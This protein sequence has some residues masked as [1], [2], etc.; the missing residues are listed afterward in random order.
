MSDRWSW[1]RLYGR[2]WSSNPHFMDLGNFS[3]QYQVPRLNKTA[4]RK[5][6]HWISE[7]T[8]YDWMR[9]DH[10]A[11]IDWNIIN[12][13]NKSVALRAGWIFGHRFWKHSSWTSIGS[14]GN[15]CASVCSSQRLS[16]RLPRCPQQSHHFV[17]MNTELIYQPI[18]QTDRLTL[19]PYMWQPLE[20]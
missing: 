11:M 13:R 6:M 19:K 12:A 7:Q 8:N 17:K 5:N 16:E 18:W 10:E 20:G 4:R 15:R 1:L 9:A 3:P 14:A 2:H